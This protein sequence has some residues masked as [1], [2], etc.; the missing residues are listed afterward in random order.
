MSLL[1]AIT[2]VANEAGYTVDSVAYASTEVTTKQLVAIAQRVIREMAIAFP[3]SRLFA[4]GSITLASGTASYALPGAFSYYHWE[5]FWNQSTRW[6]VL[7]PMSPE[8]YAQVQGYGLT[9]T[10]YARF[11]LQGCT[12][13]RLL[14]SPTP[15]SGDDGQTVIFEYVA[16]RPV[17]P[18][19]WLVGTTFAAGAYCF[20][21]GNYYS[22]TAGGSGGS[23]PTH[24]SG[25]TGLWTYYDGAYETFLADTDEPVLPQRVLEQG[26]LERFAEIHG[27]SVAPRF[28]DQLQEEFGK[29]IPGRVLYSGGDTGKLIFARAGRAVFGT[30]I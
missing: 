28:L 15:G 1:E 24:T 4:Q 23:A 17:R 10:P 13:T 16:A 30:W 12:D 29:D 9:T 22:T 25:T 19:T 27:I 18:Q 2:N 3:W 26:M 14:I 6:R 20:Y 8:E 11:M 21:N 5:T 7:G